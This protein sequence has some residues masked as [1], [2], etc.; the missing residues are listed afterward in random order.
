MAS[1]T[2]NVRL[3]GPLREHLSR[4]ISPAGLYENASEY[5]RD[6]IRRD[7]QASDAAWDALWQ[8][9]EPLRQIPDSACVAVTAEDV[10]RRKTTA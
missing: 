8:E 9:L 10:I 5:V 6:L 3:T 7:M 2:V 1:D 4:Q